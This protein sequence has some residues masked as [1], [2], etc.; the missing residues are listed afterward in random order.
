[1]QDIPAIVDDPDFTGMDEIDEREEHVEAEL[2]SESKRPRFDDEAPAE[3][4]YA[5]QDASFFLLPVLI[6]IACFIP[7]LYCLCRM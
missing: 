7:I 6:A 2:E 5:E 1:M 4:P 3:D